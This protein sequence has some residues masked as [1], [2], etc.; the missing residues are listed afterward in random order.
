MRL[1]TFL[2]VETNGLVDKHKRW[3]DP[4][5]PNILSIGAVTWLEDGSKEV[6][7]Q[8]NIIRPQG[9]TIDND[10]EAVQ[11]NG[12][13][14]EIAQDCGIPYTAALLPLDHICYRSWRVV[15][16]NAEFEASLFEIE[17]VRFKKDRHPFGPDKTRCAMLKMASIIQEPS[18]WAHGEYRWPKFNQA[19][20]H[21]FGQEPAEHHHALH[22]ARNTAYLTFALQD[23]G[24]WNLN[25]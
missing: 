5:Q 2:D 13:T 24:M 19:Y 9:F 7:S 11:V 18:P 12:I 22:D 6:Y 3:D 15:I 20:N 4:C 1:V 14:Q 21:I 17:R 23:Q 25:E 8:Y 16:Y 10:C